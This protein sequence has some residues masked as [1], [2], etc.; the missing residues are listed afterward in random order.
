MEGAKE[1]PHPPQSNGQGFLQISPL[2][3]E[4]QARGLLTVTPKKACPS[5]PAYLCICPSHLP[6]E[7]L[8]RPLP[9]PGPFPRPQEC[10]LI[11]PSSKWLKFK[12]FVCLVL[13]LLNTCLPH[14]PLSSRSQRPCLPCPLASPGA[15]SAT[16]APQ[17]TLCTLAGPRA[18]APGLLFASGRF[19]G[20][21]PPPQRLI[22]SYHQLA[23]LFRTDHGISGGGFSA[24][25]Q[26]L[27][28]TESRWPWASGCGQE[29]RLQKTREGLWTLVGAL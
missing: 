20:A 28:A 17:G 6:Q 8:P 11:S 15:P 1:K 27:N 12:Q 29:R 18:P 25:Y 13:C 23:V 14:Q 21:E 22:S 5:S 4:L 19:C 3:P 7:A 16:P 9:N 24:T 2:V 26:A 10:S